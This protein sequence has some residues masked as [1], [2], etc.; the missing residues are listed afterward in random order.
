MK[1][2]KTARKLKAKEPVRS[3][4]L[5][6]PP[7]KQEIDAEKGRAFGLIKDG[8]TFS[9]SHVRGQLVNEARGVGGGSSYFSVNH[10]SI[11]EAIDAA[12]QWTLPTHKITPLSPPDVHA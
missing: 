6:V 12:S 1:T 5:V 7:G 4:G 11:R 9:A 10:R 2:K 8:E 3:T